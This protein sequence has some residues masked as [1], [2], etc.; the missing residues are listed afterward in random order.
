VSQPETIPASAPLHL[1]SHLANSSPS[2]ISRTMKA[3]AE[4]K[5]QGHQV[6]GVHVG[7]P[8]FD[9]PRH[10]K[11]AG[12]AAI[13]GNDTHY[14][15]MDGTPDLKDAIALKF[16]REN[17]LTFTPSEIVVSASAKMMIFMAFFA[18]VEPGDE[19][20]VPAPYRPYARVRVSAGTGAAFPPRQG[21]FPGHR[22]R[23]PGRTGAAWRV[24]SRLRSRR[25]PGRP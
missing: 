7:E 8:D 5:R 2:V 21:G 12:I 10:I 4:R 20:I 6:L 1:S 19:I 9:T 22:S 13:L 3:V 24:A 14:T 16:A 15:A 17:D 23:L 18:A 11:E 25:Y